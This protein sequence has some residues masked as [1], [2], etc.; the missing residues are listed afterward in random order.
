MVHELYNNWRS[1]IKGGVQR[2]STYGATLLGA[3]PLRMRG[4]R[5]GTLVPFKGRF[6]RT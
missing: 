3:T 6:Q 4:W 2:D 1:Q 5:L